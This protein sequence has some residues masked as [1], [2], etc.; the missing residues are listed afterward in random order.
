MNKPNK[1]HY[2]NTVIEF[3]PGGMVEEGEAWKERGE[4][5]AKKAKT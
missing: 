5:F 4:P 1:T 2:C 3:R